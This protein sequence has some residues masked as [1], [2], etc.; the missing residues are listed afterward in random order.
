MTKPQPNP[1]SRRLLLLSAG[2]IGIMFVVRGIYAIG[3]GDGN[4]SSNSA[5][6]VSLKT[7]ELIQD[8]AKGE[9]AAFLPAKKPLDLNDLPFV[10]KTGTS[11]SIAAFS[12]KTILA[13]FW[14]TWCAPCRK[15]M[16]ALN[17]LQSEMGNET[18]AV[19]PV[20][21]DRGQF[22]K[23]QGF[24]SQVGAD[25]LELYHEPTGSLLGTLKAKA[26]GTG[27]PTTILVGPDGCE[28]GT[29]Y[30]PAEWA[31]EEAKSLIQK[32]LDSVTL[33]K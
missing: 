29:L 20:S 8:Q 2:L 12:G 11:Q 17:K 27:L 7:A 1:L 25:D 15:E 4:T 28:I 16:P 23:P 31:S 22:A 9:M 13:N 14:A 19:V 33:T 6:A 5:C 18:F 3:Q 30:G 32:A 21:M 24:L 26:R 10:D